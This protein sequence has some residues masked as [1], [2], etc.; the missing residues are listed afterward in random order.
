MSDPLLESL[1]TVG[2]GYPRT[3]QVIRTILE[4]SPMFLRG[5]I[6]RLVKDHGAEFWPEAERLITLSEAGGGTPAEALIEYTII[7][8]R[9]Q[10]RFLQTK[11]YAYSDFET[12]RREVYDNPDVMDRFYL[13]G[14]M[15]SH[16]FWPIHFDI[17]RMF[18]DEFVARVPD[19]RLGVEFGFGHGLYLHDVLQARPATTARGYDISEYSQRYAAKLLRHGGIAADRFQLGFAD[20]RE[21]LPA[22]PG[23]FRWA[24]FAEIIEHIPDP[25][26]S[27]R[28]LRRCMA[29]G[30][31]VFITTVLNNNAIDHLYLF[32]HID[33][34]RAMLQEAGFTI[35]VEQQFRVADYS[36]AKDPSVDVALVCQPA[37]Q[38]G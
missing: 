28:H 11:E 35:L 7:N 34:V 9:E 33:Q 36:S 27:L 14:L 4:R 21:P 17:H 30:A 29:P 5:Q 20:V 26:T 24:I 10:V 12:A 22:E 1:D 19:G 6:T 25:L 8:L 38:G 32:T 3:T 18:R 23:E 31:P 37:A 2:P 15:L 13:D 16:A